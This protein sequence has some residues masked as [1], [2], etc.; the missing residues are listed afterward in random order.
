MSDDKK[1]TSP[2]GRM[3]GHTAP[4]PDFPFGFPPPHF[5]VDWQDRAA[6]PG[7]FGDSAKVAELSMIRADYA[8]LEMRIYASRVPDDLSMLITPDIDTRMS[9]D[10]AEDFVARFREFAKL[11]GGPST[12]LK[13]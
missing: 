2:T 1:W 12:I 6:R 8:D 3:S 7:D 11:Y 10:E 5:G 4:S 13:E 9:G